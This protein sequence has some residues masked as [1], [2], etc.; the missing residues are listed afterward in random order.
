MRS[1]LMSTAAIVA[2]SL[3]G[4]VAL[5]QDR[6]PAGSGAE[7][8]AP[9]E[10]SQGSPSRAAEPKS[11]A[12]TGAESPKERSP[13]SAERA[14]PAHSATEPRSATETKGNESKPA[15][16]RATDSKPSEQKSNQ[17]RTSETAK[18]IEAKP[19]EHKPEQRTGET[20]PSTTSGDKTNAASE[21][22]AP[23]N[24]R[25]QP[26]PA[27]SNAESAPNQRNEPNKTAAPNAPEPVNPSASTGNTRPNS[28]GSTAPGAGSQTGATGANNPSGTAAPGTAATSGSQTNVNASANL[29]PQQQSKIVETLRGRRSEAVTNVN[30]TVS[31]GATVPETVR[32]H[33]V[34]EDIVSIA[35]Q[36]RGYHYVMVRDEVVI[37]EPRTRKIVTVI[38]EGGSGGASVRR[39]SFNLPTEKRR[40]IKTEVIR[41]YHGPRDARFELRVGERVPDTVTL[42]R[43]PETIFAE[44][45]EL[46]TYEYVVVQERV[47]LVDPQS[48][49]VVEI[50]D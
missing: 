5:A 41:S 10:K 12:Q 15:G 11:S 4:V 21:P 7:K 37:I 17:S 35:P 6:S 20:K 33:P 36:Y 14:A 50:F 38:H 46:K 2:F 26:E 27:R 43:F 25:G 40:K 39:T 24:S 45:P 44:E 34:P 28:A 9:A 31:V 30:F 32:Y 42:E 23:A 49:E 29:E 13:S 22:K 19:A 8:S 1:K 3:S 47:V 18:P 16:T 48:R